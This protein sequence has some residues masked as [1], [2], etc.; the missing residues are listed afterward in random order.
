M[1]LVT[2]TLEEHRPGR[3]R[4]PDG[5]GAG[6]IVRSR[7][8]ACRGA[9]RPPRCGLA[10]G[11]VQVALDAS[12]SDREDLRQ[13]GLPNF[14][15]ANADVTFSFGANFLETWIS[16]VAY[17]REY[18]KMRRANPTR[19]GIPGAVRAALSQT[20]MNAD[21]WIPILPGHRGPGRA[22]DRAA[23]GRAPQ[24]T[25]PPIFADMAV[26]Q[27]SKAAGVSGRRA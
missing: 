26:D 20:A 24:G 13:P 3:H 8:A 19:P 15:L 21:K 10:P 4:L 11:D 16:P 23:R 1:A 25:G 14:D 2:D 9:R 6:P 27:V 17:T 7:V 5:V 18:S 12:E 22:G